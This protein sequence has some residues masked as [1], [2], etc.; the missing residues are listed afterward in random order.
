MTAQQLIDKLEELEDK[1][2]PVC[3]WMDQGTQTVIKRVDVSTYWH[4]K[5][6]DDWHQGDVIIVEEDNS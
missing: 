3:F 1:T 5:D 6:G 4:Y 2:L